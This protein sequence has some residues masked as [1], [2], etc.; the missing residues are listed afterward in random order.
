MQTERF[1]LIAEAHIFL[2][3]PPGELLMIRRYNTG[4][5][6]GCYSVPAGHS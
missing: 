1:K 3:C 5:G 6:D 2:F 4:F